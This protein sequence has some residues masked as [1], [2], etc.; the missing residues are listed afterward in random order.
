MWHSLACLL[1]ESIACSVV[2]ADVVEALWMCRIKQ[3]SPHQVY[4]LLIAS[5]ENKGEWFHLF[6]HCSLEETLHEWRCH[7]S[8]Q[9]VW[10]GSHSAGSV[11]FWYIVYL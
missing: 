11:I 7:F 6:I 5:F 9:V 4:M 2:T 8:C 3:L 1:V 10:S